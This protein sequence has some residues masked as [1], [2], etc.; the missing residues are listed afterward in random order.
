MYLTH[1]K[2]ILVKAM[3]ETFDGD[4]VEEDF[5]NLNVSSE[6]PAREQ[7]IPAIWVNFDPVGPLRPVGLGHEEE[8]PG[9]TTGVVRETR[10]SFA[11]N[12][13]YTVVAMTSLERDRLFDQVVATIAFGN[14]EASRSDFR[15]TI[16]QDPLMKIGMSF[17]KIDQRGL[18][19]SPGTPWGTSDMMYEASLS[20]SL[21][22]EFLSGTSETELFSISSVEL[23]PWRPPQE[24]DP[25]TGD[26][27][28]M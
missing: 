23:L 21:I 7:S 6:F 24:S 16:E 15:T 9:P 11:G 18:A 27:W 14:Y 3:R 8:S 13:I 1:T 17:D 4:Y 26:G 10:W 28:M 25:T 12:A 20:M 22:G 2:A 19:A 5:R